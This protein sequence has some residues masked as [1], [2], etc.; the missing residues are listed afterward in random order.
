MNP[1]RKRLTLPQQ[2]RRPVA[3][4]AASLASR[5]RRRRSEALLGRLQQRYPGLWEP[6]SPVPL[7]VGIHRQLYPVI[8]AFGVSRK[9]LRRFLSWWTTA[10]AYHLALTLPGATR[11]NLDGS[12]AGGVSACQSDAAR[13]RLPPPSDSTV[14]A[15]PTMDRTRPSRPRLLTET[16]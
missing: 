10:P 13:R 7:A 5:A 4:D 12:P 1:P 11:Y 6:G 8:D 16:S 2:R 14:R 15:A 3:T 9:T